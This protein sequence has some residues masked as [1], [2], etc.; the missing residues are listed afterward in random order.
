MRTGPLYLKS[1]IF[2]HSNSWPILLAG[3]LKPFIERYPNNP[4]NLRLNN[5]Q[6]DNVRF[7]ILTNPREFKMIAAELHQHLQ[8]FLQINPSQAEAMPCTQSLFIDFPTNLVRYDLFD[9]LPFLFEYRNKVLDIDEFLAAFWRLVINTQTPVLEQILKNR[10]AFS[11]QLFLTLLFCFSNDTKH[12]H[13]IADYVQ[14][15]LRDKE[16]T[17]TEDIEKEYS[18]YLTDPSQL[19]SETWK[20]LESIESNKHFLLPFKKLSEKLSNSAKALTENQRCLLFYQVIK[21]LN[22]DLGIN[23]DTL[24]IYYLK[25]MTKFAF[26]KNHALFVTSGLVDD[27]VFT[28]STTHRHPS[29]LPR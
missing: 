5:E 24:I 26:E 19:F 17:L 29:K 15:L 11:V 20:T 12:A 14:K 1:S 9:H 4:C 2:Y 16:S 3:G 27:P 7:A 13:N 25:K 21:R 22:S 23:D 6:G 18:N 10:F 8:H 28:K